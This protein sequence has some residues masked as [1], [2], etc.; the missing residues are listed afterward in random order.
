MNLDN[1]ANNAVT[2]LIG[3]VTRGF[4]GALTTGLVGWF[5]RRTQTIHTLLTEG[6]TV[7]AP[8]EAWISRGLEL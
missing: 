7:H 2:L 6:L 3:A 5:D 1:I 4:I 8:R